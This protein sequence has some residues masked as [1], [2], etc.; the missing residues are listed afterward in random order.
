MTDDEL[1][2]AIEQCAFDLNELMSEA[3]AHLLS[4]HFGIREQESTQQSDY[5]NPILHMR[6]AIKYF[7][8]P[9]R[10]ALEKDNS[11]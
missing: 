7:P 3:K 4:V 2:E 8:L 1:I 5:I 10:E 9:K 11:D 6:S